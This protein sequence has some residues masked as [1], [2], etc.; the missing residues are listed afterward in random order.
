M[1]N[2]LE[3]I[4]LVLLFPIFQLPHFLIYMSVAELYWWSINIALGITEPF[5]IKNLFP[6]GELRAYHECGFWCVLYRMNAQR[7]DSKVNRTRTT[8]R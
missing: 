4:L 6:S 3:Y 8:G 2:Y 5:E 7:Q 1:T